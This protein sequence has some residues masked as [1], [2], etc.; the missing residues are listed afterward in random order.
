MYSWSVDWFK[1]SSWWKCIP[2]QSQWSSKVWYINITVNHLSEFCNVYRWIACSYQ[3][4]AYSILAANFAQ[5]LCMHVYTCIRIYLCIS[6]YTFVDLSCM[7]IY[8]D[9]LYYICVYRNIY[10]GACV[11]VQNWNKVQIF[12]VN[13]KY[14]K[15]TVFNTATINFSCLTH[16]LVYLCQEWWHI[17]NMKYNSKMEDTWI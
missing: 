16:D 6:I 17:F 2:P 1:I 3:L 5:F 12:T 8:S 7:Y 15:Y 10:V 9:T 14:P 11:P 13:D 4:V